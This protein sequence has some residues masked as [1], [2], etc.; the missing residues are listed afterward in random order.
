[1]SSF[2][3]IL[4]SRLR[5]QMAE[6]A[7]IGMKTFLLAA[8]AGVAM[9]VA[10]C[11]TPLPPGAEPGP[12]NTMAYIIQI[13]ATPPGARIEVNGESI[14]NTPIQL[15]MF[16]D[17]DG[18]FHDFGSPYYVIRAMPLATNQFPQERVFMTGHMLSREDRIPSRIDF[19]M[20]QAV[21]LTS[22]GYPPPVYYGP[23]PVYYP[24]PF[25]YGPSFRFYFGP[26]YYHYRHWR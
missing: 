7:F 8:A 11:S 19:D 4:K 6:R 1:M 22:P 3:F 23:P 20:N 10:G 15:K 12:H 24:D 18:T 26:R 13:N 2:G 21:P 9:V 17:P 25:F 14:G 5:K 16:G